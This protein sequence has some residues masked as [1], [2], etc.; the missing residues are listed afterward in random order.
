[1]ERWYRKVKNGKVES[2]DSI[3]G[4]NFAGFL[5]VSSFD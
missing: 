5:S 4:S 1:M 3:F 2:Y